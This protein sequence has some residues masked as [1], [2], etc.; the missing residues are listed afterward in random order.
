MIGSFAV[1]A[2]GDYAQEGTVTSK[3]S[4]VTGSKSAEDFTVGNKI[5]SPTQDKGFSFRI[6]ISGDRPS[7]YRMIDTLLYANPTSINI[8]A[9]VGY[10]M[11][12][13]EL[14]NNASISI[15]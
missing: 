4:G 1:K 15:G 13:K 5:L 12:L 9:L 6:G 10:I 11:I 2:I 8:D 14:L 3:F 7:A